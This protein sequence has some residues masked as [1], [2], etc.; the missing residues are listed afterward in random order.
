MLPSPPC[1]R[2]VLTLRT[3]HSQWV[4]HSKQTAK[5]KAVQSCAQATG[6]RMFCF[7]WHFTVTVGYVASAGICHTK[8]FQVQHCPV[9][10]CHQEWKLATSYICL[11]CPLIHTQMRERQR[12]KEGREGGRDRQR[13]LYFFKNKN[14]ISIKFKQQEVP[15]SPPPPP[16]PFKTTSF[17]CAKMK[18]SRLYQPLTMLDVIPTL[19]M[20]DVIPT[21][22]ML[23]VIP[24]PYHARCDTNPYHARCDTNPYHARCDT[25]PY[26]ATCDT[27]PLPC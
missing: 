15:S 19:T 8:C 14:K 2:G 16:P 17:T 18:R 11:F 26:H 6:Q 7:T 4:T 25:N 12:Q 20:L 27:N 9:N 24:T 23:H 5:Q 3:H 21:L 1:L 22:T 10:Q 13:D